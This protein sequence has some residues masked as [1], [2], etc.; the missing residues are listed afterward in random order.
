MIYK[1]TIDGGLAFESA[2][3]E[4]VIHAEGSS[5]SLVGELMQTTIPN[6][7][8]EEFQIYQKGGSEIYV[9]LDPA[10]TSGNQVRE[11]YQSGA[12]I[13]ARIYSQASAIASGFT[14]KTETGLVEV[15]RFTVTANA[16]TAL[17]NH[18][19][20]P[21]PQ[22]VVNKLDT[23]L[24]TTYNDEAS[25]TAAIDTVLTSTE[26]NQYLAVILSEV[27]EIVV[28]ASGNPV[29]ETGIVGIFDTLYTQTAEDVERFVITSAVQNL[30]ANAMVAAK[31]STL[32]GITYQDEASF[33]SA[34]GTVLTNLIFMSQKSS[35]WLGL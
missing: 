29:L 10:V 26:K 9:S 5:G 23:L 30:V 11:F 15:Y 13:N 28:D 31:L 3:D 34:L 19:G 6:L 33:H 8:G 14:A 17:L 24:G 18:A 32:I 22:S 20:L 27:A 2:G 21:L 25:F 7:A 16:Q 12:T 35:A 4:L 1:A